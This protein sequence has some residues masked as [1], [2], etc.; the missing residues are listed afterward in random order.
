MLEVTKMSFDLAGKRLKEIRESKGISLRELER[1][2]GYS[3]S[4]ISNIENGKKRANTEFLA[5]AADALGVDISEFFVD[6]IKAPEELQKEGVE[7]LIFGQELEKEG[8][9]IE[10][11]KEWVRAIRA[12]KEL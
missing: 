12:T 2:I 7:W 3:H 5:K 8:I 6:K 1:R 10:Q 11:V 9:T 4:Y